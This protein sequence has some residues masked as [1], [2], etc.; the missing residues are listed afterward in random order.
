MTAILAAM[1]P[2]LSFFGITSSI[3]QESDRLY[4]E[5]APEEL[6]R[7]WKEAESNKEWKKLI[8]LHSLAQDRFR[9]RLCRVKG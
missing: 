9:N 5:E 3:P 8:D 2:L 1:I 7:Q 4:I 6:L